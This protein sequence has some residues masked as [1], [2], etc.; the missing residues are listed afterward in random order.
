MGCLAALDSKWDLSVVLRLAPADFSRTLSPS[1]HFHSLP[2]SVSIS[3]G[4]VLMFLL[5]QQGPQAIYKELLSVQEFWRTR[6]V[7]SAEC[8]DLL[9]YFALAHLIAV[10]ASIGP[11]S[12]SLY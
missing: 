2:V 8:R 9:L 10:L 7:N 3:C 1:P 11:A 12:G 6:K 4:Y 5:P